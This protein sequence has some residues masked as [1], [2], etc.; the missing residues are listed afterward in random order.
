MSNSWL[1]VTYPN[2]N[3]IKLISPVGVA[4]V[5]E[6][7]T[8]QE[9]N[10][11]GCNML[12]MHFHTQWFSTSVPSGNCCWCCYCRWWNLWKS[13]IVYWIRAL[14][15]CRCL[16][17]PAVLA[18]EILT[19]VTSAVRPRPPSADWKDTHTR[20]HTHIQNDILSGTSINHCVAAE[21]RTDPFPPPCRGKP[22]TQMIGS[23]VHCSHY[24]WPPSVSRVVQSIISTEGEPGSKCT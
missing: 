21:I 16:P 17:P 7:N 3:C 5:A 13:V 6:L 20:T 19:W 11:P 10:A 14:S 15:M 22:V 12:G 9:L 4:V 8:L 24:T 18:C 23:T 2:T 1:N